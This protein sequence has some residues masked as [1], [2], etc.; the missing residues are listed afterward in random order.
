[1]KKLIIIIASST[2]L[3]I[4]LLTFFFTNIFN[5]INLETLKTNKHLLSAFVKNHYLKAVLLYLIIYYFSVILIFP[6]AAIV[7]IAGGYLFGTVTGSIYTSISATMGALTNLIIIR[8]FFGDYIHRTY[9]QHIKYMKE[10]FKKN[11]TLFLLFIRTIGIFP[12]FFVNILLGFTPISLWKFT[13]TTALGTM[14]SFLIYSYAGSQLLSLRS[15][16]DVFTAPIIMTLIF[17]GLLFL[18]P[19]AFKNFYFKFK[20]TNSALVNKNSEKNGR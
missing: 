10:K 2:I 14:P 19:I 17:L 8:Y 12:F 16:K 5:S 6:I 11:G 9:P 3:T 18:T 4:I 13:W 7:N 20:K 15:M 1:M